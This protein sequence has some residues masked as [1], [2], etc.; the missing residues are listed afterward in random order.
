M[1]VSLHKFETAYRL[2]RWALAE[3]RRLDQMRMKVIDRAFEMALAHEGIREEAELCIR[4]ILAPVRLSLTG[5]DE[6]VTE[7]W[8]AALAAEIAR[9]VRDGSTRNVVVYQARR[10]ALFDMALSVARG[11]WSRAWAWRQLELWTASDTAG[12]A[13]ALVQLVR[14]LCA[15]PALIVPTLKALGHANYLDRLARRFTDTQWQDLSEAALVE[16]GAANLLSYTVAEPSSGLHRDAGR[17]GKGSSLLRAITSSSSLARAN[18][19]TRRAVAGLVV[20][21]AAPASLHSEA[22]ATLISIIA[23]TIASAQQA[24]TQTAPEV[25][26]Y[27]TA[28][29]DTGS[30]DTA[31]VDTAS[32]DTTSGDNSVA[33]SPEMATE[34]G[35]VEPARLNSS[36]NDRILGPAAK[37][38]DATTADN[39]DPADVDGSFSSASPEATPFDPQD[40]NASGDAKLVKP[41]RKDMQRRDMDLAPLDSPARPGAELQP[42]DFRRRAFTRFGGLL[43]LIG[44]VEDLE[45]PEEIMA[46]P[47]LNDRPFVWVIHQ[48]ALALVPAEP[49]DPAALAFAGLPPD[50]KAPSEDEAP[51]SE[52]EKVLLNAFVARLVERLSSLL[53]PE[54]ETEGLLLE[55]ICYRRAEIVADPGWVEVRLSLDD[56]ATDI[57]RA[58]LDLNPGYVPWLGVVVVFV[59]E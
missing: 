34:D 55:S 54:D 53:D 4:N 46:Q 20:L 17:V 38:S 58:G 49:D 22:A 24:T 50:V 18:A 37:H 32:G 52:V 6:S 16:A 14:A 57:R 26:S 44:V 5:G 39:A 9:V 59:Y 13:E 48:L 42:L 2:P 45:L 36:A 23:Q 8:S 3:R 30:G 41:T 27:D 31:F 29:V 25:L 40:L 35:A 51:A 21:E 11:D 43:F 19:A 15:A 12:E 56:V 7:S 10:D 33:V 47:A 1:E 28:F